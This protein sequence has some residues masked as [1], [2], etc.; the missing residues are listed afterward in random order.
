MFD[1]RQVLGAAGTAVTA[2]L[3]G[4]GGSGGTGGGEDYALPGESREL[5]GIEFTVTDVTESTV[6]DMTTA[7]VNE[8]GE[9]QT[10]QFAAGTDKVENPRRL[11]LVD[12]TAENVTSDDQDLPAPAPKIPAAAG[13]ITITGT[14]RG[15]NPQ[16]VQGELLRENDDGGV[17]TAESFGARVADLGWTLSPGETVSGWL[18]F[19]VKEGFDRATNTFTVEI[20]ATAMRWHLQ[21]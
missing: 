7:P 6:V 5:S 16:S 14:G 17:D 4:C 13:R 18:L 3:A 21:E 9:Y 11:L 12:L 20:D 8:S 19:R 1:R 10:T 15:I 2:L